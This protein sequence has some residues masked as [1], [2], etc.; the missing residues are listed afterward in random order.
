M[1]DRNTSRCGRRV[2]VASAEA[3]WLAFSQLFVM[4]PV[5][6]DGGSPH[7]PA[8]ERKDLTHSPAKDPIRTVATPN[9]FASR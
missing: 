8:K 7:S 2:I 9:P 1:V 3:A 4:T 6:I 5:P